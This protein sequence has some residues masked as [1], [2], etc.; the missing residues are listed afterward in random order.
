V[1]DAEERW[2]RNYFN[3]FTEIEEH[4]QRAR[5]TSL[6]LLSP[7][8]W[9]LIETWKNAG[10]PLA[11]VLRGIDASFEKWHARKQKYRTINSLAYCTQEVINEAQAMADGAGRQPR[12][13]AAAPFSKDDVRSHLEPAVQALRSR[14]ED[15][16]GLADSIER[17]LGDLDSHFES[18]EEL[19][20]RLTAIEQK[21]VATLQTRA[22]DEELFEARSEMDRLVRPY[23][24]KMSADQLAMLEKQYMERVLLERAGLPRLSLFYVR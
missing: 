6:F 16:A 15:Y 10:I 4:F 18:L 14:G 23:R 8:D 21:M 12:P 11:A 24:S 13:A 5:G 20:Q 19:E 3:Y 9:A 22:T 17:I 2:E 1:S 7:I